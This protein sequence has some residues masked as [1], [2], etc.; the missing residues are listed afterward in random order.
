LIITHL[1]IRVLLGAA[2]AFVIYLVLQWPGLLSEKLLDAINN[3]VFVFL[4]MGIASGF[5]ERLFVGTPREDLRQLSIRA[6]TGNLTQKRERVA[7]QERPAET[8]KCRF[9]ADPGLIFP[10]SAC[11]PRPAGK[12]LSPTPRST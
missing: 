11:L 6:T 2:G 5:S 10:V 9:P 7:Q 3:N 12:R 1:L 8:R 4:A